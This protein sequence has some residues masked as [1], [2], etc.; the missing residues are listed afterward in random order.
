MKRPDVKLVRETNEH[1]KQRS[2]IIY[3]RLLLKVLLSASKRKTDFA[4]KADRL[5]GLLRAKQLVTF[6]QEACAVHPSEFQDS[7]SYFDAA[8]VAALVKKYPWNPSE[9]QTDPE[10]AAIKAFLHS[11]HKC[12]RTN[13][14]FRAMK[15][16]RREPYEDFLKRARDWISYVLGEFSLSKMLSHCDFGSGASI[17]VHGSATHVG[18]KI[19]KSVWTCTP[20]ARPY[21]WS[22]SYHN[23]QLEVIS[24]ELDGD[25][26]AQYFQPLAGRKL[27]MVTFNKNEFAEKTAAAKRSIRTEPLFNGYLQK[28]ADIHIRQ[29]LRR[30]GIDLSSQER[31][32]YYARFGSEEWTGCNCFCTIDLSSASDSIARALCKALL[33]FEWYEYLNA[34]RSPM[35]LFDLDG[36]G[37]HE[38]LWKYEG[39]VSMGNGFCF[40]LET[41]LFCAICHAAGAGKP[42]KD[43]VVYGDD[44]VV[45]KDSFSAVMRWLKRLGFEPNRKKTFGDGPF[46]ESCGADFWAGEDVRPYTLD[47]ALDSVQNIFK[48]LNL[49]RRS[50][51]TSNFFSCVWDDILQCLPRAL[52]LHRPF[53]TEQSDSGV[54][55]WVNT[56]M[57]SL[58]STSEYLRW[59]KRYQSWTWVELQQV[60]VHDQREYSAK[61]MM[62][63]CLRGASSE[64]M[65]T[66]RRKTKTRLRVMPGEGTITMEYLKRKGY[67]TLGAGW[68]VTN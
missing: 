55:P 14:W 52:H 9:I 7:A 42:R 45:R 15:T 13:Q 64:G 19:D 35:G 21:Y 40:P 33:P 26:Y 30:V 51:K 68:R 62:Y 46:R 60:A 34:I 20:L 59:N 39:F 5:H 56:Y 1:L 12:K 2:G 24:K 3:R 32:Q 29:C 16:C 27:R 50:E 10:G 43:F 17:G 54:D 53:K 61:S 25:G 37:T 57:A 31:N 63:A 41:L 22:A 47:H 4:A 23:Q 66:F 58:P 65:F 67:H 36:D 48:F 38:T 6:Y 11:E 44:I 8:Q 28:G 18:R 49:C